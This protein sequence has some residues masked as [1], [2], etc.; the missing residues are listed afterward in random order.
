[1]LSAVIV[2][3]CGRAATEKNYFFVQVNGRKLQREK[4]VQ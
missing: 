4:Q 2:E 1:M 3:V